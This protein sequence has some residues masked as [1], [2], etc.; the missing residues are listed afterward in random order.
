MPEC[1]ER[2]R[3]MAA[4]M[5]DSCR[6]ILCRC[7]RLL[8]VKPSEGSVQSGGPWAGFER[9]VLS[10]AAHCPRV[11]SFGTSARDFMPAGSSFLAAGRRSRT[12]R[13]PGPFPRTRAGAVAFL[14]RFCGCGGERMS[15]ERRGRACPAAFLRPSCVCRRAR[16]KAPQCSSGSSSSPEALVGTQ[17]ADVLQAEASGTRVS[18]SGLPL[19]PER[20]RHQGFGLT[21]RLSLSF[22]VA[23]SENCPLSIAWHRVCDSRIL[24]L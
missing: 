22:P 19:A 6:E 20:C 14:T 15:W 5:S 1:L 10:L 8:L 16:H 7:P 9:S 17:L 4:C 23:V 11:T 18:V 13:S 21:P 3:V 24:F 2:A 12:G